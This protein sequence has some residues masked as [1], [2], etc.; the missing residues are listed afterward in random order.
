MDQLHSK[1]V[2]VGI[3]GS[4]A[5]VNAAKSAV[6][7]AISWQVPLRLVHVVGRSEVQSASQDIS[8]WELECGEMA[9]Y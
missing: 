4:Q 2:V 9:L 5:A 6:D 1:S 8:D 3:D 7:E